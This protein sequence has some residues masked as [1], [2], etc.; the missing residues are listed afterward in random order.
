MRHKRKITPGD[1]K[2]KLTPETISILNEKFKG[3]LNKL[4]YEI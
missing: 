4:N 3:V 1:H 2:E